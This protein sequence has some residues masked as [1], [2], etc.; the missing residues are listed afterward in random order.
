[1]DAL[2]EEERLARD[3]LCDSGVSCILSL[4]QERDL[5]LFGVDA[6]LIEARCREHGVLLVRHPIRD[7]SPEDLR[8]ALP[9]AVALLDGLLEAGHS[10]YLHCT[11]GVHRSPGPELQCLSLSNHNHDAS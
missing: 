3:A 1:M 5:V 9:G 11:A 6:A 2:C 7:F 4:Q 8:V 10:V